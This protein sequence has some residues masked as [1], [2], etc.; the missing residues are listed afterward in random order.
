MLLSSN[1][2]PLTVM[3]TVSKEGSISAFQRSKLCTV[4]CI[5]PGKL[6]A[7]CLTKQ[8]LA[9]TTCVWRYFSFYWMYLQLSAPNSRPVKDPQML[10][11]ISSRR[12]EGCSWKGTGKPRCA[13]R[14]L[15]T[16]LYLDCFSNALNLS[17]R[18][19]E[20]CMTPKLCYTTCKPQ[21]MICLNEE[22]S[23]RL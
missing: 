5:S 7:L 15:L 2:S 9:S 20:S 18:R 22:R 4:F 1:I 16:W 12:L 19:N 3:L 11:S 13:I 8:W 17:Y 10:R 14:I 21:A 23:S 6:C